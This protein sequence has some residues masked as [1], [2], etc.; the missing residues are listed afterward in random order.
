MSPTIEKLL[1][2]QFKGSDKLIAANVQALH[3]G[4]D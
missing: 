4:R 3:M 1:A 2:E